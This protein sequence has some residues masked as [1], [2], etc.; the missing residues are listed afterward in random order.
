MSDKLD[1]TIT[2]LQVLKVLALLGQLFVA[3]PVFILSIW[4]IYFGL[5]TPWGLLNIDVLPPSIRLD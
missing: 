1:T 5:E 4:A 2:V 3:I